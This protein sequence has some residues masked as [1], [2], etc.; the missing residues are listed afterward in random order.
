MAWR[1]RPIGDAPRPDAQRDRAAPQ[2]ARCSAHALDWEPPG[3]GRRSPSA[4]AM[5]RAGAPLAAPSLRH[6]AASRRTVLSTKRRPRSAPYDG[7]VITACPRLNRRDKVDRPHPRL[8]A[9]RASRRALPRRLSSSEGLQDAGPR[10]AGAR[11]WRAR[12]I[13]GRA[14][15]RCGAARFLYPRSGSRARERLHATTRP[16]EHLL[17]VAFV[18]A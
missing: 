13:G 18:T 9:C 11:A 4:P 12:R 6:A 1:R 5:R 7:P 17:N 10:A 3:R 15:E 14:P 16:L 2:V 8:R